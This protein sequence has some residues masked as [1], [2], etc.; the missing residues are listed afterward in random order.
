MGADPD[1]AYG[2]SEA[3]IEF[4]TTTETRHRAV[5]DTRADER[6]MHQLPE[7]GVVVPAYN[8]EEILPVFHDRLSAVLRRMGITYEIVYVNDG[9]SDGTSE[10]VM[11]LRARDSHVTLVNLSRNF[12]KEIA[13][14]AGLDHTEASAVIVIDAD[15]QDP[16]ELIPRLYREMLAGYDVVYAERTCRRGESWLKKATSAGFYRVMERMGPVAIPRDTG[17][18]RII[19]RRGLIAL[20]AMRERHRFMKG[21][22]A[23]IG[24]RQKAVPYERDARFAGSTKWS[25]WKLWNLAL[26]GITSFTI[27]PLKV[28]TYVGSA[29][30]I[31][32]FL[33]AA[34]IIA[35]T[36]I[37][38]RDAPGYASLMS[39]VLLL[40]GLQLLALGVIGE[41]LGRI[42][43]EQKGRPLYLT[44]DVFK[45]RSLADT[46]AHKNVGH[47][48]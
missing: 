31:V 29:T 12:G 9:S 21:L 41:Y 16:P 15:L 47:V 43:N 19:G 33:Y 30:A 8:E 42:F 7:L 3:A 40:G 32:A 34:V 14:T 37:F 10:A 39:V 45:A 28:A 1:S 26:E 6:A 36:L 18:F 4:G 23:W 24:F 20:R 25:Y 44:Q 27:A 48:A 2:R 22:F 46:E 17:D 5:K 13:L 35:R 11:A 38:G